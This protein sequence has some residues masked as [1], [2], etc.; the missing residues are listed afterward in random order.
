[1]I[2]RIAPSAAF[3]LLL[4]ACG[5]AQDTEPTSMPTEE[6][7]VASVASVRVIHAAHAGTASVWLGDEALVESASQGAVTD[8]MEILSGSHWFRVTSP[9]G[10][11]E[12]LRER[13]TFPADTAHTV[14]VL[15][16]SGN[17]TATVAEDDFPETIDGSAFGRF[18]HAVP[19]A[20]ALDFS[21]DGRGYASGLAFGD[22]SPWYQMTPGGIRLMAGGAADAELGVNVADGGFY[23]FIVV[24]EGDGLDLMVVTE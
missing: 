3:A 16:E 18:V 6:Q 12:L 13:L 7:P 24:D 15:G 19:G 14:L 4:A 20:G 9:S 8:H 22:V 5:G 1:M 17:L 10:D 2:R 23:T 21:A 11:T